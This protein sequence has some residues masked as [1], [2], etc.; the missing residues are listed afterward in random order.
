MP[1]KQRWRRVRSRQASEKD[2][3]PAAT[4]STASVVFLKLVHQSAGMVLARCLL[5]YE[6]TALIPERGTSRH[7]LGLHHWKTALARSSIAALARSCPVFCLWISAV[8][9]VM[10]SLSRGT[11]N[12]WLMIPHSLLLSCRNQRTESSFSLLHLS[13]QVVGQVLH[14]EN[15]GLL[16]L[17]FVV[18]RDA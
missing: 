18:G 11:R 8:T 6:A 7:V 12:L 1:R 4:A 3:L 2:V 10:S 9:R 13:S 15:H 5:Q 16:A 17:G 14:G